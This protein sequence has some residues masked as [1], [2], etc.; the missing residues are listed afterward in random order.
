MQTENTI[1]LTVNGTQYELQV[2]PDTKLADV[3]RRRLGL[4]G[5][6][7]GCSDGQCGTCTVLLDG[8][9]VRA[10]VYPAAKAAGREVLTVE[11]LAASWGDP[12]ELHPL[13]KPSSSTAQSNAASVRPAC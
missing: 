2:T 1:Q 5:T 12:H 3:L 4:T 10:C 8:R 9:A 6:K 7:I 13:Q 11:G